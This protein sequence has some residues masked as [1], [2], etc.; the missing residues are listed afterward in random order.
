VVVTDTDVAGNQ[1]SATVSFTLDTQIATPSAS[2]ADDTGSS[3]TD[4]ITSD[5][6]ITVSAAQ[7]AGVT[8]TYSV[9][10][11]SNSSSYNPAGLAD[12]AHTVVVTDTDVAGN[13]QSATVSFTLDT[14]ISQDTVALTHDTGS[15]NTDL[16]TNNAAL[17]FSAKDSDATRTIAVDNHQVASYDPASL[18][19]G[20]HTVSISDVDVAG[21]HSSASIT[22]T[23]DTA[24]VTPVITS[25]ASNSASTSDNITSDNTL[26][27]SGTAEANSSVVINDGTTTLGTVTADGAGHWSYGPSSALSDG[28]HT[29]TATDTDLAGN[30]STSSG[31]AVMIDTVAPAVTETLAHDTGSSST[32]LY[33]N[34]DQLSGSGD[35]NA[36]VT[37]KEGTNILGTTTAD[38]TGH[39]TF[40]PTLAD[41]AH[42]IVASE[43]DAAGNTGSASL[44]FTLDTVAVQPVI[45]SF[46]SNSA[47]TSDNITSDNTL[48][49]S[50]TAEANSS[51]VIN[52]GTTTL[53][54]VTADGTGHW[55]YGPS[56][57]LS[58][59]THTFTATDTD[60]AGNS[61]TS[62]GFAVVI[63]TSA[64]DTVIDSGPSSTTTSTSATFNWHGVDTGSGIDH[65]AYT[66]DGG[67]AQTTTATSVTF[68]GLAL[69]DHTFTVDAVDVAGNAD[70]SAATDTWHIN[71][72]D[73]G[74]PTGL[75]FA[76]NQNG[77][78]GPSNIGSFVETGDPDSV[79]TFT[80][81]GTFSGTGTASVSSTGI[82][83][84]PNSGLVSGT[85]AVTVTD[86]AGNHFATDFNLQ[87]GSNSADDTMS[88]TLNGGADSATIGDGLGGADT[89]SGTT[90]VDYLIGG[91]GNDTLVGG[92]GADI[93]F[94]GGNN[95]TFKYLAIA[96]SNSA[97]GADTILD[98]NHGADKID[99]SFTGGLGVALQTAT[100]APT[101]I[102]ANT[103]LAVVTGGNTT[104]Y[105]NTTTHQENL[106]SADMQIQLTGVTNL[107]DSDIIHHA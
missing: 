57:A 91:S 86:Q 12:G 1:Q 88:M 72:P 94:G 105:A 3:N 45:T 80:Y 37:L 28:T 69:G 27:L 81:S 60:L 25:F 65:Y 54:T 76:I 40:T 79:D 48:V 99:L 55:S 16:V 97:N 93:L 73:L 41:G 31:F 13:Q 50:G 64:P 10:G 103:L 85:L 87:V 78:A 100:S 6:A 77:N 49:L 101:S 32:D 98:F 56:S 53:G 20:Q 82:L 24:A 75:L 4:T 18:A 66:I 38:G 90:G 84:A 22:F 33:T 36:T 19:D 59:G 2:L 5:A 67:A 9:D 89:I 15:S 29:F 17:S 95:D 26:V 47:S 107:S 46:A 58:D 92:K 8:R 11:G 102:S 106:G 23:L 34:N 63:D 83:S 104:L 35:V 44:G 74:G 62:S 52:D 14:Q 96:D 43:T 68:N 61:S 30:S 70:P 71:S 21:N 51:V 39:W 7:E 42:T